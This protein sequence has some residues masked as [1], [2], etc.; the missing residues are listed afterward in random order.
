MPVVGGHAGKTIIPLI[1]QVSQGDTCVWQHTQQHVRVDIKCLHD[2]R[3]CARI[4]HREFSMLSWL[5]SFWD[6][7]QDKVEG[8]SLNLNPSGQHK[9][10]QVFSKG[11]WDKN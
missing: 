9:Q 4:E 8:N 6:G 3:K 11:V 2:G 10:F 1:S 7:V 5:L